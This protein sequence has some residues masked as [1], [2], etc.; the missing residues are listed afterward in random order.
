[1]RRS[2]IIIAEEILGE[3]PAICKSLKEREEFLE[4]GGNPSESERVQG[5]E[6][7]PVQDRV[8]HRKRKDE[9]FQELSLIVE[10]IRTAYNALSPELQDIV[11][12]VFWECESLEEIVSELKDSSINIKVRRLR[13]VS[14]MH[15]ACGEVY[16][17]VRRWRDREE[18][19]AVGF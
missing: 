2:D 18:K 11:D 12:R 6:K 1:M 4:S 5:G 15:R 19:M 10:T 7:I 13:A 8:V 17:E 3:Y 9:V 16:R 14:Q